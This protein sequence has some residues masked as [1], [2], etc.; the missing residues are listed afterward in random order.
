MGKKD[1]FNGIKP[2]YTSFEQL[3]SDIIDVIYKGVNTKIFKIIWSEIEGECHWDLFHPNK[4]EKQFQADIKEIASNYTKE[5]LD[6]MEF[7]SFNNFLD[8]VVQYLIKYKGYK[9]PKT[10]AVSF[11]DIFGT[12][13]DEFKGGYIDKRALQIIKKYDNNKHIIDAE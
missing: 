5:I 4:T 3:N 1:F 13:C 10:V 8:G 6:E 7:K 11:G 2:G 12:M 9:Y